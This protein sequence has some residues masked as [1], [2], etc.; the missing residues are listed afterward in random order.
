MSDE[1]RE[2]RIAVTVGAGGRSDVVDESSMAVN[3][4]ASASV[5]LDLHTGAFG[6]HF[7]LFASVIARQ[8]TV[9]YLLRHRHALLG[10]SS[11]SHSFALAFVKHDCSIVAHRNDRFARVIATLRVETRTRHASSRA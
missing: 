1:S 4:T 9:N 7:R 2:D 11:P 5:T 10:V 8:D 3:A 6:A